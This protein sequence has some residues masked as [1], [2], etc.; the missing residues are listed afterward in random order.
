MSR[1][2]VVNFFGPTRSGKD[3]L[4][5]LVRKRLDARPVVTRTVSSIDAVKTFYREAYL[6]ARG[7]LPL[8]ISPADRQAL[9]SIKAAL[10]TAVNWTVNLAMR[11]VEAVPDRAVLLYQAR[12]LENVTALRRACAERGYGFLPVFLH[13][14]GADGA[15]GADSDRY[16]PSA[17][18]AAGVVVTNSGDLE[19]LGAWADLIVEKALGLL[20]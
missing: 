1:R 20:R 15:D 19:D 12:E 11:E 2:L 3:A 9:S 4:L 8:E 7:E 13:R 16:P 6:L 14:P 5:L 18:Q 17:W 10:D